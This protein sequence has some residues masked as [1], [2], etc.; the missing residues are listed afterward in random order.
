MTSDSLIL[1]LK[2]GLSGFVSMVGPGQQVQGGSGKVGSGRSWKEA[3]HSQFSAERTQTN[4]P[5]VLYFE[6]E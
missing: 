5:L 1:P 2:L 6:L 4:V 3:R